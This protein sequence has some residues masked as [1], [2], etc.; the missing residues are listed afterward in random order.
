MGGNWTVVQ[1]HLVHIAM[2]VAEQLLLA[3]RGLGLE[4]V[5]KWWC[6]GCCYLQQTRLSGISTGATPL[7]LF[8]ACKKARTTFNENFTHQAT[9]LSKSCVSL[10][11][12][13]Q[14]LTG[15]QG[16]IG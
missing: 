4:F 2:V 14:L 6:E 5:P 3:R 8:Y 11:K 12:K 13:V 7:M 15:E 1:L 16:R 10:L 9:W